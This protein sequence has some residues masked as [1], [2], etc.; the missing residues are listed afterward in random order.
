MP[1]PLGSGQP[2]FSAAHF[3]VAGVGVVVDVVVVDGRGAGVVVVVSVGVVV[4]GGVV[5]GKGAGL[6]A[7][8]RAYTLAPAPPPSVR[9]RPGLEAIVFLQTFPSDRNSVVPPHTELVQGE[10]Q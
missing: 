3:C 8:Q 1:S 6:G 4:G 9:R 5:V 10:W 7:E 2:E